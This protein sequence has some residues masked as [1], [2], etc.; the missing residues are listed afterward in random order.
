MDKII[1]QQDLC[2]GCLDCVNACEK[3]YGTSR[4]TVRELNEK[5]Y[6]IVCQQCEDAPCK[7]ICTVDAIEEY[8]VNPDR[9]IACGLCVMVCPFGAITVK[10]KTAH[11]CDQCENQEEGPVCV[12]ACSKRAI[13]K[14]DT[15]ALMKE[16]QSKF[17]ST[18]SGMDKK[19][20]GLSILD[21]ITKTSKTKID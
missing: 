15:E 8:G 10:D 4:I 16:K 5:F 12:K 2:D 20:K 21:M 19:K 17:I 13:S 18:L 9:C 11:K 7:T 1:I 6:P 3:M 14:V